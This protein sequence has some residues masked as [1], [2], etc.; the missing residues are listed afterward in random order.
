MA[1]PK[2]KNILQA[3][4]NE[5]SPR[6]NRQMAPRGVWLALIYLLIISATVIAFIFIFNSIYQNKI[7][8]GTKIGDISL[9]GRSPDEAQQLLQERMN[10]LMDGGLSFVYHDVPFTIPSTIEDQAN[11]DLSVQVFSLDASKTA[12]DITAIQRQRHEAERIFYWLAGWHPPVAWQLNEGV[13]RDLLA[14]HLQAYQ[15]PAVNA[16]LVIGADGTMTITPE[17]S[18]QAFKYA[19]IIEQINRNF[20][21]LTD[22]AI[23]LS[24]ETDIP[25]ITQEQAEPLLD[26]AR[27]VLAAVPFT[28]QYADRT[29]ELSKEKIQSWLELQ[30]SEGQVTVGL[31]QVQLAGF[32][33]E[34]AQAINVPVQEGKFAMANGKV[35]EFQPSQNGLEL[36]LQD[37]AAII[38]KKIQEVGVK[39][40]DLAVKVTEPATATGD[41]NSL[42]VKELIGVGHSN[43]KGSPKN[44]RHNISVGANT[45]NGILI[46]PGEEFSLVKTLGK[47]EASTGYLPELVIKG[48]RTIPE[49]GGGLCQIG[50]TTFR[51]VLDAGLPIL[52]RQSHSYRVSY[53]E[54]AGTDATIYDPKPDF[55][56]LNDT[57]HYVLFTTEMTGDDLYFRFYGT[58]DGRKVEQTKPRIYNYVSPGPT[59]LIETL[60]LKPGEKKCTE[61]AHTGADTEFTR[62]VTYPN[63]EK[64]V[65]LFKSHY[66]PWAEVCLVGAEKTAEQN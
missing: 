20:N 18:G 36:Q 44:R 53:Y 49:Y 31:N 60:S 30:V 42:G 65:D 26:T 34:I 37:S 7:F 40:I 47:I 35:S 1:Q 55:R 19:T 10:A 45:L 4:K 29:W 51:V 59:K 50:T 66:K 21:R 58:K 9:G 11:P 15:Q 28:V 48:N 39:E 8:P 3:L 16:A 61:R 22:T 23:Q 54:P 2:N 17:K 43:F 63:G 56:F 13:F 5:K 12:A 52:E 64:K 38:N 25:Q 46:K 14:E 33:E 27:Q 62:T 24:L 6:K 41:I 32:L 57:G